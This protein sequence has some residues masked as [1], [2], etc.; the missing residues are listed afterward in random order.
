MR[1][2]LPLTTE[3]RTDIAASA[4]RLSLSEGRAAWAVTAE[5]RSDRAGEDEE[6]L[7]YAAIQDAVQVALGAGGPQ[8]RALVI[9]GDVPQTALRT[10]QDSRASCRESAEST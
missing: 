6:E 7:E 1:I 5:V 10:A 2:F 9:A 8:S 4:S 3:D